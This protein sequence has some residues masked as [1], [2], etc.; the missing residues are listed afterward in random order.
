MTDIHAKPATI[1]VAVATKG[2]GQVDLHFGHA[3]DFHIY[4]AGPG[5]IRYIE[6][7]LVEH[8][9]Q[10]GFGDEDK[11]EVIVRALADCTGLL[12]AK[13]GDGPKKRLQEAGIEAVDDYAYGATEDSVKAWYEQRMEH[14]TS[15]S[16]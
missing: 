16:P 13:I 3:D 15:A 10:G 7:R 2:L 4:E 9:C 1:K 8:Y 12:V 14:D 11:R 6:K 5:G